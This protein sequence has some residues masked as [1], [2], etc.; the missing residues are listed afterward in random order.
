[1]DSY[2]SETLEQVV[3]NLFLDLKNGDEVLFSPAGSSYDLFKNYE[4]RGKAFKD[5]VF[6]KL[7]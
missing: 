6:K 5:L 3:E 1:M 2:K 7:S 4:E